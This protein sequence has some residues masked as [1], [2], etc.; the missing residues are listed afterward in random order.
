L[1]VQVKSSGCGNR[2]GVV[3]H[4]VERLV[5][6]AGRWALILDEDDESLAPVDQLAE[7]G[8]GAARLVLVEVGAEPGG[9]E[10]FGGLGGADGVLNDERDHLVGVLLQEFPEATQRAEQWDGAQRTLVVAEEG[11]VLPVAQRSE[12]DEERLGDA[13][14]Q[15]RLGSGQLVVGHQRGPVVGVDE[16]GPDAGVELGADVA[17]LLR[18][19]AYE[20]RVRR[21][22][23]PGRPLEPGAGPT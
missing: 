5:V 22:P 1:R 20:Q 8:P 21:T 11:A 14:G 6:P 13:G 16:Q 17:V 3:L 2:Y 15:E 12:P 18:P 19:D 4:L 9:T 7:R 23:E 10:R